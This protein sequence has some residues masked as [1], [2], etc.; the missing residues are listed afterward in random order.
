MRTSRSNQDVPLGEERV[1]FQPGLDSQHGRLDKGDSFF[2]DGAAQLDDGMK[3]F[4]GHAPG[5]GQ[6]RLGID[7]FGTVPVFFQGLLRFVWN[8]RHLG[9]R[10]GGQVSE[11]SGNE[12]GHGDEVLNA[13]VAASTGSRFLECAVHGFDAAVVLAGF[14]AVEDAGQVGGQ[15][16]G[17]RLS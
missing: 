5:P 14:E 4:P 1:S 3:T 2:V 13:S 11:F 16:L 10:W 6:H 12:I 9:E 17:T 15:G 8:D 7:Q